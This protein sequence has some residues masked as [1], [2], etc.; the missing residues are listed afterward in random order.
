M[1]VIKIYPTNEEGHV[2]EIGQATWDS[3]ETSVRNR[4]PTSNGGF[5][6]RSSSELPIRDLRGIIETV[7]K[8]DRLEPKDIA[9]MISALSASLERKLST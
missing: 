9:A 4:Y 3:D 1:K 6:P 7:A 2:I 5:S 8:E